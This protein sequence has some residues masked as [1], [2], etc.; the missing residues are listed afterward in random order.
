MAACITVICKYNSALFSNSVYLRPQKIY[1]A[2]V[3][4]ISL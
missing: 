1:E 3:V 4:F 2:K